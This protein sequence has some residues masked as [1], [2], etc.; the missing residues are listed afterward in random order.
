MSTEVLSMDYFRIL[1]KKNESFSSM[2]ICKSNFLCIKFNSEVF[3][4]ISTL[5]TT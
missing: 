3:K 5:T 4:Y 1:Y 2:I